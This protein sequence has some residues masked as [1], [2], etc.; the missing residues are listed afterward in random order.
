[1]MKCFMLYIMEV[2]I[3]NQGRAD[4]DVSHDAEMDLLVNYYVGL[5]VGGGDDNYLQP[6]LSLF[7]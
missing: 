7:C 4:A 5:S 6:D 2:L 3:D 1:M